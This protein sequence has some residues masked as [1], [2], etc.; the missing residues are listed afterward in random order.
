M[1]IVLYGVWIFFYGL[2]GI[3]GLM[4]PETDLQAGMMTALSVVFFLPAWILL[5]RSLKAGEQKTVKTVRLIC[6]LSL[7]LTLVGFVANIASVRAT[8]QTGLVLYRIL[9]FLSVP[10]VCSRHYILSLF[11]WACLLFATFP[12]FRKVK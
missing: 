5:L 12:K 8:E 1:K 10:M 2:C 6:I 7:S 9:N 3:L 4:E 11:L